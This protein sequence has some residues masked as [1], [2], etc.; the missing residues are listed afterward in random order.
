MSEIKFARD[1]VLEGFDRESGRCRVQPWAFMTPDNRYHI[2]YNNLYLNGV[3]V[4]MG[5]DIISSDDGMTF[6]EPKPF[7][8][9]PDLYEEDSRIYYY[10]KPFYNKHNR[11]NYAVG[12]T[13]RYTLGDNPKIIHDGGYMLVGKFDPDKMEFHS[14]QR[15]DL[16]GS[17]GYEGGVF[18]EP[19]EEEGGTILA[20]IYFNKKG[21]QV[22][23]ATVVRFKLV[24]GM[25]VYIEH[26][27]FLEMPET[28]RGIC[29]PRIARL[30]K[31][32]YITLR[33]DEIGYMA[34]SDDGLNYSQPQVWRWDDGEELTSRNTQQAWVQF[35]DKLLLVYT[36]E[37]PHNSHIFRNRAPLFMAEFDPERKC[38]I[39]ETERIAVPEMG[40]RIGN[41]STTEISENEVWIVVCEWMQTIAPNH[42]D[43]NICLSYGARNRLW[44]TRVT[45]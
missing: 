5:N 13:T 27:S 42:N 16:P 4:F 35:P 32:Y 28:P 1:I 17:E 44:R 15:L 30:G 26:G 20:P 45:R 34:E 39:K 38:L 33:T 19:V 6:D 40:A 43:Y 21:T 25:P 10:L 9:I 22:C 29:E 7:R 12:W 24:D 8:G 11:C 41:F 36:R 2:Y 18:M 37:T 23:T 31:K 14:C 3:D